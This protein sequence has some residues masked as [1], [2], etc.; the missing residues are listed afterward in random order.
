MEAKAVRIE[1]KMRGLAIVKGWM[2]AEEARDEPWCT[3][4]NL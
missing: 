1:A 2:P 4:R 3:G